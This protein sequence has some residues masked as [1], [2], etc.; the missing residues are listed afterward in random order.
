MTEKTP[1]TVSVFNPATYLTISRFF[2]VPVFIYFFLVAKFAIALVILVIASITDITDG[3]LARRFN[4][5]TKIGSVLDPLAD[6]FLMLIS[7]LV[8]STQT[9][10]PWQLATIVIGRDFY[11][12][13]GVMYLYFVKKL[14]IHF[15]PTMLSKRTTFFQFMCLAFSFLKVYL[16]AT[17]QALTQVYTIYSYK[18]NL[19]ILALSMHDVMVLVA[20]LFT[21][22]TFIQ[23][24]IMGLQILKRNEKRE[25]QMI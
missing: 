23:Y 20:G 3:L 8:L 5:G 12:V 22:A 2:L 14:K 24:T 25:P 4:M 11:I 6:K 19:R 21:A 17:P 16:T 9:I 15:Q 13:F 1:N 18:C 7:F 10:L